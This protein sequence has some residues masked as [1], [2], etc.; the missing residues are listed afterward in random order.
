MMSL[1][2]VN[3]VKLKDPGINVDFNYKYENEPSF[4]PNNITWI[5]YGLPYEHIVF[6]DGSIKTKYGF[7]HSYGYIESVFNPDIKYD[8]LYGILI[9]RVYSD[10]DLD[11]Y[12]SDSDLDSNSNSNSR[13]KLK[14]KF[15]LEFNHEH[16]KNKRYLDYT[17]EIN[18][19]VKFKRISN[20]EY[21]Y[22]YDSDYNQ[23]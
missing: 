3:P 18:K 4:D 20:N 11:D 6:N 1:S 14:P 17:E 21:E 5:F 19:L 10:L 7:E 9:N 8:V 16:R 15:K 13:L 23:I 2:I 12:I 22:D